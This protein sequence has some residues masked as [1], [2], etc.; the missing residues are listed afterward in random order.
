MSPPCRAPYQLLSKVSALPAEAD[1]ISRADVLRWFNESRASDA[2]WVLHRLAETSTHLLYEALSD[3]QKAELK[4]KATS[5]I[6]TEKRKTKMQKPD[7]GVTGY[8]VI[9]FSAD[10]FFAEEGIDDVVMLDVMRIGNQNLVSEVCYATKDDSALSGRAYKAS[11]GRLVF[12]PGVTHMRIEIPII[13]NDLWDTTTEFGCEF[14]QEGLKGAVL[15]QYLYKTRVMV[16]DNNHFPTDEFA[17][18]T[19]REEVA[20]CPKWSLLNGYCSLVLNIPGIWEGTIKYMMVDAT[21]NLY[22]LFHLFMSVY[23]VDYILDKSRAANNLL[24]VHDKEYSLI[25]VA[26]I[27]VA[28]TGIFH[29]LDYTKLGFGVAGKPRNFVQNALLRKF[30]NYKRIVH[31]RLP[32]GDVTMGMQR[33]AADLVQDGYQGVLAMIQAL[34]KTLCMLIFKLTSP[35]VFGGT[36]DWLGFLP[37]LLFPLVLY[38]F[39]KV[40]ENTTYLALDERNGRQSDLAS[41]IETITENYRLVLDYKLQN[42]CEHKFK[43]QQTRFTEATLRALR[44]LKNNMYFCKWCQALMTAMWL[45]YGGLQVIHGTLS[46]GFFMTTLGLVDQLGSAA[47]NIYKLAIAAMNTFPALDNVTNLMNLPTEVGHRSRLS[48]VQLSKSKRH[49]E[50]IENDFQRDDLRISIDILPITLNFAYL[51]R[52]EGKEF[53]GTQLNF[54]GHVELYQGQLAVVVGNLGSGKATLL[55]LLVG[56]VLPP[57]DKEV[58]IF[59]PSHLRV[60]N[61]A[62]EPMFFGG[63]LYDNLV[64]GMDPGHP[65]ASLERV[66]N[67]CRHLTQSNFITDY[68]EGDAEI[69]WQDVFSGAQ[70]KLLSISRALVQ[71]YELIC[72]HKPIAKLTHDDAEHV[73]EALHDHI[74]HRGLD[75]RGDASKRRP[76]TVIVSA[77]SDRAV[78]EAHT[79]VRIQPGTGLQ[80]VRANSS[81]SIVPPRSLTR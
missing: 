44:I 11:S 38:I 37:L 79:V 66:K 30:L 24:F 67:I 81:S 20:K 61:V 33:D 60:C 65:D 19:T 47:V 9:Q 62:D 21:H 18:L 10:V 77:A 48:K 4:A 22:Y 7:V 56:S 40:R 13:D 36:H 34:G 70:C 28:S 31:E 39:L 76:R 53:D 52:F 54:R 43:H 3:T 49:Q 35:F 32:P 58:P 5:G 14:K 78:Q 46:I 59:V 73:L 6:L 71:N 8:P 69:P 41:E 72:I 64:F 17:N 74:A 15:G 29:Y 26:S 51:F 57:E 25:L 2:S 12:E 27:T 75:A 80:M 1:Q 23:L 68:L 63:T 50:A 42:H 45:L 55:R 16:I